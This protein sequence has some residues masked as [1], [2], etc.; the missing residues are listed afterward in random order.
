MSPSLHQGGLGFKG[1]EGYLGVVQ[2][3]Y[4][5]G[6]YRTFLSGL[7]SNLLIPNDF[8]ASAFVYPLTKFFRLAYDL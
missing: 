1:L 2:V 6:P 8:E 3:K 7:G 5:Y 4:T